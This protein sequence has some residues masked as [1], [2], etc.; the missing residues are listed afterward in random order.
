M[1]APVPARPRTARTG[2]A[3]LL[4]GA[5][6]GSMVAGRMETALLCLG[7]AALAGAFL[8]AGLPPRRWIVTLGVGAAVA[9]VMNAL[10]LPGTEIARAGFL[11]VTAEGV[12]RGGLMALR[13]AGATLALWGLRAAWPGERAADEIARLARPLE[14]VRVP[15][16]RA[17]AI[18]GLALRFAPLLAEETR[19][20][21]AIQ[22]LRAGRSARG[23][24]ER[25]ARVQAAVV[26]AMVSSLERAERV[27]LALEAR[28]ASIRQVP[29]RAAE[30]LV[31]RMAGWTL[32]GVAL[33]WRA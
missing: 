5:L 27:A 19:R 24:T 31:A 11:R 4:L 8:G 1:T 13:L 29:A 14:W 21:A 33:V 9:L 3:P 17:R 25:L 7:C 16:T 6:V 26:P 10:L 18:A 28:H 12:R 15:V 30:P 22:R 20:I 23:V 32:A 2:G